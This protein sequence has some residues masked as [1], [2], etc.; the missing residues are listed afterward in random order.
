MN[1]VTFL[2]TD[3]ANM[4]GDNKLNV[5][6]VFN[7]IYAASFPARHP[8]MYLVVKLSPEIGELDQEKDLVIK[9]EDLDSNEIWSASIPVN[10]QRDEHGIRSERGLILQINDFVFPR[11]GEFEFVAYMDKE[12]ERG[13]KP[14]GTGNEPG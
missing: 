7:S 11:N 2:L 5:M 3:Y 14:T 4:T 8:T 13:N 10:I 1:L 6:G 9:F 12:A